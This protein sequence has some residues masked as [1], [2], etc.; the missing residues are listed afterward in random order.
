MDPDFF[1]RAPRLPRF[2][3]IETFNDLPPLYLLYYH[4]PPLPCATPTPG[5][6]VPDLRV[7]VG[8]LIHNLPLSITNM[9]FPLDEIILVSLVMDW[10]RANCNFSTLVSLTQAMFDHMIY[11]PPTL[12]SLMSRR[13]ALRR[14][15]VALRTQAMSEYNPN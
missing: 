8:L 6:V 5:I 14:V 3:R 11:M 2:P 9:A 4:E 13:Q 12:I 15:F 10:L 1:L 7:L